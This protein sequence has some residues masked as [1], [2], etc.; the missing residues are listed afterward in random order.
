MLKILNRTNGRYPYSQV[1]WSYNGVARS[2]AEQPYFD[3]PVNTAGRMY[4]HL[5]SPTG[6][7]WDFI[8]FTVGPSQF[9]GNTTRGR[10]RAQARH[11]INKLSYG[12]PYDDYADQSSFVSA[13]NPRYLLVAVGW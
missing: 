1:Y 5:G 10:V 11:A 4:F 13:G 12:F 7:Y 2:I 3:M 6:Q 9:N 8:E